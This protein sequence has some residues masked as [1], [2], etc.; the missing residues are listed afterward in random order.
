M[1]VGL[2]VDMRNPAAW[3]REPSE[4]YAR[5]L[6]LCAEADRRG[7]GSIWFTE[8]HF[9]D[10][11]Y[12]PQPLTL[13]AAVAARTRRARLGTAVLLGAL[14]DPL[15]TA[16]QAALVDVLSAGRLELGIGPGYVAAEF[17]RFGADFAGRRTAAE[18][19]AVEVRHLLATGGVSPGPVQPDVPMWLG[20]Q[21][22]VGARRTG[23]LGFGLLSLERALLEPLRAGRAAA[24]HDPEDAAMAGVVDVVVSDD[25][26]RDAPVV[27]VHCGYQQASYRSLHGGGPPALTGPVAVRTTPG[28][29]GPAVLTPD[30]AA[31]EIGARVAGLPVH[32]VY[33]WLSVAGMPDPLVERHVELLCDRVIPRLAV[34]AASEQGRVVGFREGSAG[35]AI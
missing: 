4:L 12:L 32:H 26:E 25:P 19:H 18:A 33:L 31:A 14:R 24:G 10:D 7:I 13:A 23:T 8:H 30:D 20:Y 6:D 21:G 27:G 9:V 5:T 2:F 1:K 29:T 15:H 17:T 16:E 3:R 11:G 34:P 35:A 22:P 28:G